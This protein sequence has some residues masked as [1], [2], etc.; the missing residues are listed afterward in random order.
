[1][2]SRNVSVRVEFGG[3]AEPQVYANPE[4]TH[5][6]VDRYSRSVDEGD[7]LIAKAIR[8]WRGPL[9][10]A[11]GSNASSEAS[12]RATPTTPRPPSRRP[13]LPQR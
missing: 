3:G 6:L 9:P 7:R 12:L 10:G 13:R 8:R 2:T 5:H 11:N 1:M 4:A